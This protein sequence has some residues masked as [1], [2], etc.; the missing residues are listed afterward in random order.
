[1]IF[2]SD[3][4]RYRS[5][6]SFCFD[7]PVGLHATDVVS[8]MAIRL[9]QGARFERRVTLCCSPNSDN[10]CDRRAWLG[11]ISFQRRVLVNHSTNAAARLWSHGLFRAFGRTHCTALGWQT[12]RI[13]T[14]WTGAAGARWL[15]QKEKGKRKKISRRPVNS[16][17]RPPNLNDHE[18]TS[19]TAAA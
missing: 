6:L 13:T 9:H 12:R 17:V 10:A 8:Q 18:V 2:Q 1:M 11:S 3:A 7:F 14:R 19:N 4:F 15:R 16:D 5:N